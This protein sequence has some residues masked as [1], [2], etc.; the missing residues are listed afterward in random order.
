MG[1]NKI[2]YQPFPVER[3]IQSFELISNCIE[4]AKNGWHLD[5][6]KKM[7]GLFKDH[8]PEAI[9]LYNNLLVSFAERSQFLEIF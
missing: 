5:C 8:N 7:M 4:S 6:C 9:D 2:E 3:E 1:K